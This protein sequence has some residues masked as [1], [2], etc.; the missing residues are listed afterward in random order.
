[1]SAKIYVPWNDL[2]FFFTC[3]RHFLAIEPTSLGSLSV[4]EKNIKI[5]I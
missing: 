4:K 3:E 1:M 5:Y 2:V